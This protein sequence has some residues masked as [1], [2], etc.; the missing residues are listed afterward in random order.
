MLGSD[1]ADKI[2]IE[3]SGQNNRGIAGVGEIVHAPGKTLTPRG[4]IEMM[5]G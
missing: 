5:G 1:H 3:N 2:G 4:R